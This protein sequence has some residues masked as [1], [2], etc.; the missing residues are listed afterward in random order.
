MI[1]SSEWVKICKEVL[2]DC[3]K[4]LA[5]KSPGDTE[6]NEDKLQDNRKPGRNSSSKSPEWK[7]RGLPLCSVRPWKFLYR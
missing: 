6:E 1:M 5:Q 3:N 4:V 7:S 2:A